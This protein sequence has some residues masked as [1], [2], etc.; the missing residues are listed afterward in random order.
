MGKS[1][2]TIQPSVSF[3]DGKLGTRLHGSAYRENARSTASTV[4][5]MH[6]ETLP[7]ENERLFEQAWRQA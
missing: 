7:T 1:Q 2:G 5:P 4:Q 3:T 6:Q